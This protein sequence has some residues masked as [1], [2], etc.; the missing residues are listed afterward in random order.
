MRAPPARLPAFVIATAA[1]VAG[2]QTL[3]TS[4][5]QRAEVVAAHARLAQAYSNCDE[6]GFVAGYAEAFTFV[7]SNTRRAVSGHDGLRAYLAQGCRLSPSPKASVAHQTV[8][9]EGGH[10]VVTGQY[11][12][13]IPVAGDKVASATQN[14]TLVLASAG[15][16]WKI[17]AHHVSLAP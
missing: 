13:R 5:Q 17:V 3:P 12:F 4:E 9:V 10:A 7:T 15:G 6:A 1:L 14:F 11:L 2:C 16:G 8:H